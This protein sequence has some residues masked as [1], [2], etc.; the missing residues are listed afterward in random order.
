MRK[1]KD[2]HLQFNKNNQIPLKKWSMAKAFYVWYN[3]CFNVFFLLKAGNWLDSWWKYVLK[4][5]SSAP[6]ILGSKL[7]LDFNKTG[8][9]FKKDWWLWKPKGQEF[10]L[11]SNKPNH[12]PK[13]INWKRFS[14]RFFLSVTLHMYIPVSY[15]FK[16]EKSNLRKVGY[17]TVVAVLDKLPFPLNQWKLLE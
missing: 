2:H 12:L 7:A 3:F 10:V 6:I 17:L 1:S 9:F 11:F 8:M 16:S 14:W 13:T 5:A 15:T 4:V